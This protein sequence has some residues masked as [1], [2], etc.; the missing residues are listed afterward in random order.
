MYGVL[1]VTPV[2]L[3]SLTIAVKVP[4]AEGGTVANSPTSLPLL[5]VK[6][7]PLATSTLLGLLTFKKGLNV[8]L[9]PGN[10]AILVG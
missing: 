10:T 3:S 4:S 2:A 9:F 5:F 7:T 6:V 8:L 1:S